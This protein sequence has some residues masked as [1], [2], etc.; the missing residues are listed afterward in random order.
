MVNFVN[1]GEIYGR[2]DNAR[3]NDVNIAGARQA[4][5]MGQYKL[6]QAK[7]AD[8]EAM[9]IRDIYKS[10]GGDLNLTQKK[11]SEMG[12]FDQANAVGK[13]MTEAQTAQAGLEKD[14]LGN[15]E[16]KLNL[17]GQGMGFVLQNPTKDNALRVFDNLKGMGVLDDTQ[18]QAY[19]SNLPD[20]PAQIKQ[21]AETLIRMALDAKSQLPQFKA[22]DAGGQVINQNVNPVTGEVQEAGRIDKTQTPDSIASNQ[23]MA[24]E[25]AANRAVQ[26]RGQNLTDARARESVASQG[27]GGQKAP[28]GYRFLPDGSLEAIKGGPADIKAGE[29]G[30]KRARQQEGAIYQ[31]DRI[32]GKV[33]QAL[34]KVSG[35][36]AGAGYA[37]TPK[38][39]D[40]ITGAK[41]LESDLE[42][43]K[44][45]LGFAELQAMRDASP[46]GGALGQ[47]AVQ[48]LVALQSTIASLDQK[49][50]PSQLK[51]RLGEIKKHYQNWKNAVT[52]SENSGGNIIPQGDKM[53]T[54]D[55]RSEA[56]KILGL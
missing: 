14:K 1:L 39:L 7:R 3:A 26:M 11:L 48:E 29:L 36:T 25:G 35:L 51:A 41:D 9:A 31:A 17:V 33:D 27:V 46:T 40:T 12:Y 10:T 16:K 18:Y 15:A 47:V 43:I 13:Q 44:A 49:Q 8:E 56:D 53:P 52:Q 19:V 22:Q 30:A 21:G 42:T 4:Q 37:T 5:E 45:N 32:I 50:S 54:R 38:T 55:I 24:S 20:D 23:R 34:S 28:A 6:N 2:L